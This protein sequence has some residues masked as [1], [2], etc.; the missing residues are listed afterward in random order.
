MPMAFARIAVIAP[1][2]LSMSL[3]AQPTPSVPVSSPAP[4]IPSTSLTVAIADQTGAIIPSA[5]V[6]AT[7]ETT[8]ARLRTTAD[9]LGHAVFLL[10]QGTYTVEV[11][12]TGFML[13]K[14]RE[15]DVK[16]DARK[17]V[18]LDI[19]SGVTGPVFA[20]AAEIFPI[21]HQLLETEITLVP[22]PQFVTPAR[23][24]RHKLHWP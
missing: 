5:R 7:N 8:G 4:K 19:D 6:A 24:L 3:S 14:K 23:P 21:D 11:Q 15:S 10:E 17:D 16:E 22:M 12:S 9:S 13:W 18:V 1:F 20:P 2:L